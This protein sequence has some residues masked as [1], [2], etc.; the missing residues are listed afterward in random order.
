M[1]NSQ[2]DLLIVFCSHRA[3]AAPTAHSIEQLRL[4]HL[5][6]MIDFQYT[7]MFASG[8]AL[9][10]RSRSQAA[11]KFLEQT[12]APFML[13]IDDDIVFSP[14][15]VK[16]IYHR[17]K[18]D[19]Y[20]L[21]GGV[22][23][24]RGASQLSSYG[25]EGKLDVDGQIHDIE[26]LATGFMG[27]SRRL[28]DKMVKEL[29]M[30]TLNPNDWSRCYAFFEARPVLSHEREK[31]GDPIY[32]S[33]DWF[34]CELARKVG[35]RCFADTSVQVGH[36]REEI[37]TADNVKQN[38]AQFAMQKNVYG[39]MMHQQ[40]LML[41]IDTDLSEFLRLPLKE[42][43]RRMTVAQGELARIWEQT[44]GKDFYRDN[45]WYLFDLAA[46]NKQP[47][48]FQDRL[49]Q[50][51][52]IKGK[53]ILDIGSGIGTATFMMAEQGNEVVGWD[54]NKKCV[55][56]ANFRKKKY[57]LKGEFTTEKPDFAQFNV[58]IAV[59]VLEHIKDLKGFL[60]ELGQGMHSGAKLYHSDY[61]PKD[62]AWPM[63][64]EEHKEHLEEWLRNAGLISWDE[65]WT[66]KS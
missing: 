48:Y 35:I 21:I 3:V 59:D 19:N 24:V 51:L 37:F 58:I 40:E 28:L 9:L 32:I 46:F 54:I 15:D 42:S 41:S 39:G 30:P 65:R 23:P 50:L 13:F 33:E 53:K 43:Q 1:S 16:T 6:G 34:F 8:D 17:M 26:F 62:E 45:E 20:D 2:L 36:M 7:I 60:K 31:G 25:W 63:H 27:I 14:Q 22:Y 56:F 12:Q 57:D 55:D 11:T 18:D 64:Y 4:A 29:N 61:F 47:S 66:V 38:Q 10:T 49:G 5:S 52:N 44:H